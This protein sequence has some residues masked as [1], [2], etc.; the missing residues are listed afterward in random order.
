[1]KQFGGG[2]EKEGPE[3]SVA[4]RQTKAE[5][6]SAEFLRMR[7]NSSGGGVAWRSIFEF[8]FKSPS[9]PSRRLEYRAIGGG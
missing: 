8:W 6:R 4:E 1:V 5:L 9:I 3:N 2:R 7:R